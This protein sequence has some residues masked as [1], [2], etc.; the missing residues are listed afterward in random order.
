MPDQI[1]L[2]VNGQTV[3]VDPSFQ[4]LSQADQEATINEI[5]SHME[6]QGIGSQVLRKAE[7]AGGGLLKG[8]G[9]TFGLPGTL[10]DL[11]YAH[12]LEPEAVH[13]AL[14]ILPTGQSLVNDLGPLAGPEPQTETEKYL[15]GAAQGIGAAIPMAALGPLSAPA[16]L[17]A[18]GA[19]AGSGATAEV[20]HEMFPES[21]I[22]PIAAGLLGGFAGEGPG[23]VLATGLGKLG[24]RSAEK[25]ASIKGAAVQ[26]IQSNLDNAKL[27]QQDL[28][29]RA[30]QAGLDQTEAM[31]QAKQQAAE[32]VSA[33]QQQADE[34][35]GAVVGKLGGAKTLQEAGK[36]VQQRA[37]DWMNQ[38]PG[39]VQSILD[40][41][42]AKVPEGSEVTPTALQQTLES[43]N[44]SAGS[45][46]GLNKELKPYLPAKL[47]SRLDAVLE[48]QKAGIVGPITVGDARALRTS[49]GEALSNPK[50]LN[51]IGNANVERIYGALTQDIRQSLPEDLRPEWD[52]ANSST[53]QLYGYARNTIS[54]VIK[55][56]EGDG[57]AAPEVT[58]SR[59][60]NSAKRGGTDL[61]ALRSQ[62]PDAADA[63]GA[64]ILSTSSG[65]WLKLAPEAKAALVPDD[66]ARANLDV[67]HTS[68]STAESASKTQLQNLKALHDAE[69]LQNARELEASRL[70]VQGHERQLAAAKGAKGE[71]D[72]AVQ[73]FGAAAGSA[74]GRQLTRAAES[75]AGTIGGH[76]LGGLAMSALG[77]PPGF[78]TGASA[79]LGSLPYAIEA[80]KAV[81]RNPRILQGPLI[82]ATAGNALSLQQ[83]APAG[84]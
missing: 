38:L 59:L 64:H 66:V 36:V 56:P 67:A 54:K 19:G 6:G 80:A 2:T 31:M 44:T 23:A 79:V 65:D 30:K 22:A 4:G 77:V 32:K 21:Q 74:K 48:G 25:Q 3:M 34:V 42:Y 37:G 52:A 35:S 60:V 24:L 78:S 82:G 43:I 17:G 27:L 39:K 51:D 73:A 9:A 76:A 41:V 33:A 63:I 46:E 1:P 11:A 12:G 5:A 13:N 58:A 18:A 70:A 40:P 15:S 29:D 45:L 69:N 14:S 7:I 53:H 75:I 81:G 10:S 83:Q 26:T 50:L 49:V 72:A 71:A 84:Q 68:A 57:N 16:L 61:T 62:L 55:S 8:I 20:A 28:T 47:Q